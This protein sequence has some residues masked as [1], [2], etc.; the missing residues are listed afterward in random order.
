MIK[1]IILNLI[2]WINGYDGCMRCSDRWNWKKHHTICVKE[3][4]MGAFPLCEECWSR[5][6]VEE[7]KMYL[8]K[9]VDLW[10]KLVPD[11]KHIYEQFKKYALE[12]IE[13]E[14]R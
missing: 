2:G 5:C 13:R 4:R 12:L 1:R 14:E 7:R 6:S 8:N 9:L 3:M 10:I 11:Q